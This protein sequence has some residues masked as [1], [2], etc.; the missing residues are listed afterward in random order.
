MNTQ[1]DLTVHTGFNPALEETICTLYEK[2]YHF[3]LAVFINTLVH[4]GYNGTVW[5]GYRGALPPWITQLKS[6]ST[7]KDGDK[8]IAYFMLED[9]VR[10]AFIHVD[11]SYHMANFKPQFMLE[12]FHRYATECQYLWYFDPDIFIVSSWRYFEQ[13]QQCGIAL[14]ADINFSVLPDNSPLR[15]RW[16]KFAVTIGLLTANELSQY[17]NSGMVSVARNQ[18]GFIELWMQILKGIEKSG[19]DLSQFNSGDREALFDFYDQDAFNI[20]AMYTS[21]PLA[22]Q[23]RWAMGFEPGATVMHHTVGPKPWRGTLKRALQGHAPSNAARYFF[24]QAAGPIRPY[25]GKQLF[26]R[27]TACSIASFIGRFYDRPIY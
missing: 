23:G 16:K 18:I 6:D 1:T 12:I 15:Y 7:V 14:C 11:P 24:M 19:N 2:D 4:K 26:L 5:I 20:A 13:W 17:F 27:K 21:L 8:S 3:G 10:L 25:S 22:P 9:K